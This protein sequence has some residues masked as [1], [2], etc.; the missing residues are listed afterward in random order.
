MAVGM[1]P[2]SRAFREATEGDCWDGNLVDLIVSP[3]GAY[4]EPISDVS[5]VKLPEDYE[6]D[7]WDAGREAPKTIAEARGVLAARIADPRA[8]DTEDEAG[9]YELDDD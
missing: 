6:A 7:G 5:Q 4:H 2:Q 8:P 9:A 1:D 3:D